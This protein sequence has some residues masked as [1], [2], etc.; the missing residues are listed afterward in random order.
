MK[1]QNLSNKII[2]DRLQQHAIRLKT[3][4]QTFTLLKY[5]IEN[6]VYDSTIVEIYCFGIVLQEYIYQTHHEFVQLQDSLGLPR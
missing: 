1:T 2:A 4:E 6:M 3:L 5:C